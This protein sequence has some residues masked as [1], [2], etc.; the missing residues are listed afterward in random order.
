MKL[1]EYVIVPVIPAELDVA[2]DKLATIGELY[3]M[4]VSLV[5]AISGI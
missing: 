4:T 1:G 5:F 2:G 3:V